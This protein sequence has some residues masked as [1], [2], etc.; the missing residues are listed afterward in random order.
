MQAAR[1][2]TTIENVIDDNVG[3]PKMIDRLSR[4]T[5]GPKLHNHTHS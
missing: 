4:S 1:D 2:Q 3:L 5:I